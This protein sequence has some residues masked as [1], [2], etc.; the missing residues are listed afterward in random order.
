MQK[1]KSCC[2]REGVISGTTVKKRLAKPPREHQALM[3][4]TWRPL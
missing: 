1:E 3:L 2:E 4:S